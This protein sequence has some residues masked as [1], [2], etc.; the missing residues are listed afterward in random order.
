MVAVV[1]TEAAVAME[2]VAWGVDLDHRTEAMGDPRED[3]GGPWVA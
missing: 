1:V 2:E 3:M